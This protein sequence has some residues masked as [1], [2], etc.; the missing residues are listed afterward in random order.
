M[1]LPVANTFA[2]S[3]HCIFLLLEVDFLHTCLTTSIFDLLSTLRP[4]ICIDP[5]FLSL[6]YIRA[7]MPK[8][9]TCVRFY[10]V[11]LGYM[12]VAVPE[13]I[14]PFLQP[15]PHSV[16]PPPSADE[17]PTLW[18]GDLQYCFAHNS[19]VLSLSLTLNSLS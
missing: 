12:S 4:S 14:R 17:V 15:P 6:P 11:L 7:S 1:S 3:Y 9:F 18:I 2:T 8:S 5:N 19:E 13:G 16:L 10:C